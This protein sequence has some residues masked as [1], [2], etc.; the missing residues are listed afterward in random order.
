MK[1]AELGLD[2][3][4]PAVTSVIDDLKRLEHEGYHFEAAADASLELLM[5]RAAGWS[6]SSSSRAC[7]DHRRTCPTAASPPRPRSRCGWATIAG[8]PRPRATGR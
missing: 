1:A 3:D 8:C 6:R 4:G 2:M 5:R 7:A